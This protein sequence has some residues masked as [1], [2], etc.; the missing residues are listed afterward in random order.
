MLAYCTRRSGCRGAQAVG[1]AESCTLAIRRHRSS[2]D[3]VGRQRHFPCRQRRRRTTSAG[4][5]AADAG[6]RCSAAGRCAGCPVSPAGVAKTPNI[7]ALSDIALDAI[8]RGELRCRRAAG[9]K[10]RAHAPRVF[11]SSIAYATMRQAAGAPLFRYRLVARAPLAFARDG[12]HADAHGE[13]G[14]TPL[15]YN[16]LAAGAIFK[17]KSYHLRYYAFHLFTATGGR[18]PSGRTPA[19]AQDACR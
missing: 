4:A 19:C 14:H 18:R 17:K 15:K 13:P 6:R 10:F 12:T 5:A 16:K 2:P 3:L 9:T 8:P 1:T 11:T 7:I